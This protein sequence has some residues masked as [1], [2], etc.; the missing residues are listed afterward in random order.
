M[1]AKGLKEDLR[2][3]IWSR[4]YSAQTVEHIVALMLN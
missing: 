3:V 2:N 4:P 1:S